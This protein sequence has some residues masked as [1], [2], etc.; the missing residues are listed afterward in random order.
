MG[1]E[2][3]SQF[4]KEVLQM[5][6][7]YMKKYLTSLAI[8]EMQIKNNTEILSHPSHNSTHQENQ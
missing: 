8:K 1:D 6:N 2:L 4:L 5:A 7:K 3:N